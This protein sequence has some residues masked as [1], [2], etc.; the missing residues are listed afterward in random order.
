MFKLFLVVMGL[1]YIHLLVVRMPLTRYIGYN[2]EPATLLR[3]FKWDDFFVKASL[4]FVSVL[5]FVTTVDN[6]YDIIY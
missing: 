6:F 3:F 2:Y 4:S 5:W 1:L